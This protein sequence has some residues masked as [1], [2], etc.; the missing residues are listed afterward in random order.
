MALTASTT[1][2]IMPAKNAPPTLPIPASTTTMRAF[3]V[4]LMPMSGE[5]VWVMATK[6]PAM[7]ARAVPNAKVIR[8]VRS[9]LIPMSFADFQFSVVPRMDLPK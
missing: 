5:I 3:N 6:T 9:T 7:P 1:P 2:R 4:Q 8:Y